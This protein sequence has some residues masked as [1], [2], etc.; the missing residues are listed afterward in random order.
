MKRITPIIFAVLIIAS[1]C[2]SQYQL[3]LEGSNVEA[4]YAMAMQLFGE[5]KYSRAAPLFESLSLVSAGTERD[6]TVQYYWGLSN[7]RQ[8]DFST[9]GANF[10]TFISHYPNSPFTETAKYYRIDCLYRD[11]YRWSLDQT[12]TYGAITSINQYLIEKPDSAHAERCKEMLAD[13]EERLDKKAYEAAKLYYNVEDYKASGVA[14]RNILKDDAS[15]IYREDILYYTA[16]SS[17]KYALLSVAA[18]QKE[19]YMQFQDDYLNFISEYP[20]SKYRKELD[21][22][23]KK[24]KTE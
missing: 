9:A 18:K 1:S 10:D 20:E 7:Y 24:L 13:L 8:K 16:M 14:F 6:D 2:K 22:L 23:F 5:G 17:Y 21:T 4:K 11:T 19:R 12:P 3:V 15:N